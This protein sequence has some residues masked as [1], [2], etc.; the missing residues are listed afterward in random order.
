M[1]ISPS[2]SGAITTTGTT[3]NWGKIVKKNIKFGN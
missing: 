1:R 2:N 3:Q